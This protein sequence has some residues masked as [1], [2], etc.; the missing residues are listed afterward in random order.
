MLLGNGRHHCKYLLSD[1]YCSVLFT[2]TISHLLNSLPE[3]LIN[4]NN[5]FL[6]QISTF[7]SVSYEML[8]GFVGK[9]MHCP[10]FTSLVKEVIVL[11][12]VVCL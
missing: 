8:A 5:K 12:V 11:V 4:H 3:L 7:P 6:K 2:I 9:L 1:F 10:I